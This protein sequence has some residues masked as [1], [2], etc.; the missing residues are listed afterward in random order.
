MASEKPEQGTQEMV[1][2]LQEQELARAERKAPLGGRGWGSRDIGPDFDPI[3]Q[4]LRDP[5]ERRKRQAK[6]EAAQQRRDARR[7]ERDRKTSEANQRSQERAAERKEAQNR[8]G[9]WLAGSPTGGSNLANLVDVSGNMGDSGGAG[10]FASGVQGGAGAGGDIGVAGLNKPPGGLGEMPPRVRVDD[11]TLRQ[12][13]ALGN[14]PGTGDIGDYIHTT[15]GYGGGNVPPGGLGP[16]D[17]PVAGDARW[18][19]SRFDGEG[20][21]RDYDEPVDYSDQIKQ[22][23]RERAAGRD[24]RDRV[25]RDRERSGHAGP[26]GQA[27]A[28]GPSG[29]PPHRA[30]GPFGP[31]D[32]SRNVVGTV[33][34]VLRERLEAEARRQQNEM[35]RGKFGLDRAS[36]MFEQAAGSPPGMPPTTPPVI[37]AGP[38]DFG[39]PVSSITP[40]PPDANLPGLPGFDPSPVQLGD[41]DMTGRPLPTMMNDPSLVNPTGAGELP[42][43]DPWGDPLMNLPPRMQNQGAASPR[44]ADPSMMAG[45]PP[46]NNLRN[47]SRA[48]SWRAGV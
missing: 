23:R 27:G 48:G 35:S 20:G 4:R 46:V 7:S 12:R 19:P 10:E 6:R 11:V 29:N 25:R 38:R 18:D 33:P 3:G 42:G 31:P 8:R 45:P 21:P 30:G 2:W 36:N 13:D 43:P 32:D 15:Q 16:L 26:P 24:P 39:P 22:N 5:V 37:G 14:I 40:L 41:I 1:K 47:L 9:G 28:A 34:D 44:S 17:E